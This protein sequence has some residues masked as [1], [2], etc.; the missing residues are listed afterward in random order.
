ML[1]LSQKIAAIK[2][3][4]GEAQR[5]MAGQGGHSQDVIE[6]EAEK[7]FEATLFEKPTF[8]LDSPQRKFKMEKM[9]VKLIE[10]PSELPAKE[11]LE[12]GSKFTDHMLEVDWKAG[13]G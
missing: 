10:K 13:D 3:K 8:P 7:N 4:K 1:R 11:T 9:S 5:A 12:F 2:S 6:V